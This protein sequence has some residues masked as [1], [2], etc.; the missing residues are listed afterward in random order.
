MERIL[1]EEKNYHHFKQLKHKENE[2]N[3]RG[4]T[5]L[6]IKKAQEA[7]GSGDVIFNDRETLFFRLY[8][9]KGGSNPL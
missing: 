8:I 7:N 9:V 5:L 6:I 2:Q 3:I 4:I 1:N